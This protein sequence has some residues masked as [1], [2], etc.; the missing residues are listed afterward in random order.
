MLYEGMLELLILLFVHL[1]ILELLESEEMRISPTSD[2]VLYQSKESLNFIRTYVQC[3]CKKMSSLFFFLL[4]FYLLLHSP[5]LSHDQQL[6]L[7]YS[8]KRHSQID[9]IHN[10][11]PNDEYACDDSVSWRVHL[12]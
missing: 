4:L 2:T 9:Q 8:D 6:S 12:D 7:I 3:K 11:Q 1:E 10:H 5:I